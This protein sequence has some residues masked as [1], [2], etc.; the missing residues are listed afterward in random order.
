M[1]KFNI[2]C[3]IFIQIN[4][5]GWEYLENTVGLEYIKHCVKPYA[6][7]IDGEIW[8]Q[9]QCWKVF[10]LFPIQFAKPPMINTNIMFNDNIFD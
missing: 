8:Y 9:L 3:D 2:N 6:R 7:E 4:D 10:E 1:K 5:N